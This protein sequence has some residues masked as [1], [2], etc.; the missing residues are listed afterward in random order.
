MK[1]VAGSDGTLQMTI[2]FRPGTIRARAQVGCA[3]PWFPRHCRAC[4]G[5][6]QPRRATQ[7]RAGFVVMVTLNSDGRY[8]TAH[9][10]NYA[11]SGSRPD[12]APAAWE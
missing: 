10:R 3:K 5:G 8:G 1:S 12:R 7:S 11:T 4:C 6:G 9:L 2:T